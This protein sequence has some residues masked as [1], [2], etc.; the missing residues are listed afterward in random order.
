VASVV[1]PDPGE[2][3]PSWIDRLA[4]DMHAAMA[5]FLRTARQMPA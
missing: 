4:E 3:F 2:S 5:K 1:T